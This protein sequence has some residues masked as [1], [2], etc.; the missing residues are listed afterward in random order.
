MKPAPS[1]HIINQ[2]LGRIGIDAIS[3]LG[4]STKRAEKAN[5]YYDSAV[6]ELLQRHVWSFAY[7]KV[8]MTLLANSCLYHYPADYVRGVGVSCGGDECCCWAE[9]HVNFVQMNGGLNIQSLNCGCCKSHDHIIYVSS[10]TQPV[11]FSPLFTAGLV[12]LL[13]AKLLPAF[14]QDEATHISLL[15]E[16][17]AAIKRAISEDGMESERVPKTEARCQQPFFKECNRR[18]IPERF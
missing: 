9:K 3:S 16:S 11:G 18:Y 4:E 14:R 5:L 13:A 10:D 1:I 12:S 7:R 6:L 17:D 15:R 8:P 2:A